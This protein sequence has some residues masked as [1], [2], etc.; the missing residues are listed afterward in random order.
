MMLIPVE[1]ALWFNGVLQSQISVHSLDPERAGSERVNLY[2]AASTSTADVWTVGLEWDGEPIREWYAFRAVI[3]VNGSWWTP[4]LPG[5][6]FR[7]PW[8]VYSTLL[9]PSREPRFPGVFTL[10]LR[11]AGNLKDVF[12]IEAKTEDS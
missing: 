11:V 8:G 12:G 9:L 10:G 5:M 1:V 2:M 4:L 3:M 7:R 6:M